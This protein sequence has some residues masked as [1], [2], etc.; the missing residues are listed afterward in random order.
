MIGRLFAPSSQVPLAMQK[1]G[2]VLAV[3]GLSFLMGSG[4]LP[5]SQ[6]MLLMAIAAAFVLAPARSTG[7]G[8]ARRRRR[9]PGQASAGQACSARRARGCGGQGGHMA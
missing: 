7:P 8:R 6:Y 3:L 5:V 1:V 2:I 4:R 9:P